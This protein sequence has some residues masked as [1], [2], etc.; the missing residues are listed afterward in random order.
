M[1]EA[2]LQ[3]GVRL[4]FKGEN[5]GRGRWTQ[6]QLHTGGKIRRNKRR[7]LMKADTKTKSRQNRA[8]DKVAN[9]NETK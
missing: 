1:N 7:A 5:Y 2:A 6:T 4:G 3:S 8:K 9:K